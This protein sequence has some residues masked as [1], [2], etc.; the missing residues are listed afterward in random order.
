MKRWK[1]SPQSI[2]VGIGMMMSLALIPAISGCVIDSP[3]PL[4]RV[5]SVVDPGHG[6]SEE[7]MRAYKR[8]ELVYKKYAIDTDDEKLDYFGFAFKRLRASYVREVPDTDLI[9]AAIQGVEDA[10]AAPGTM[11]PEVLVEAALDAMTASLDPHTSYMNRDEFRES[12]V[13][14]KGEFGGLGIEVTMQDG[15]V[16][17]V[18][19]IE[20]TPAS[21]SKLKPGDLITHVDGNPI[22][23]KT[24]TEAV[25]AMRGKPGTDI[26]LKVRRKDVDDFD[27]SLTR[28]II[29]VR[30]VRW[31]MEGDIGYIRVSRF[32]ERMEGGIIKAFAALRAEYGR[33]P[34]G[35]V[36]DLRNNPGGL[37]DQSV[38]LTDSFLDS[39]EI[40]SVR[41]RD[42]RS[43][44]AFSAESGDL[45][46]G[47]PMVVLINGGSA[48]A[49]EI[50]ASALKFHKRATVMGSQSFGKGSVQTII[51]LPIDGALRLTTALYYGPDGKTLQA[52]G[53]APDVVLEPEKIENVKSEQYRKEADLSGALPAVS[54]EVKGTQALIPVSTCEEIGERKDKELGCAI[55]YLHAKSAAQ[56]SAEH[57]GRQRM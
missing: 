56:F 34:K 39:G 12:F 36:L 52:H 19:P 3:S 9:D 7:A 45:A 33:E 21:R 43:S 53:V 15:F 4:A 54:D 47:L 55:A 27:V 38:I 31:R 30:A 48:S 44:S 10:K 29:K 8:F 11:D 22:Q 46:N 17:V 13:Q 51:P 35:I 14:T 57:N 49:S 41:G 25:R 20:D 6:L 16:K 26:H 50:V 18:T 24:L 2:L 23:G 32:S 40:V 28:A 5:L 42:F 1:G 37:L